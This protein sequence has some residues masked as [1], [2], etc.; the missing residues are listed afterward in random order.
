MEKPIFKVTRSAWGLGLATV[1]ITWSTFIACSSSDSNT[2]GFDNEGGPPGEGGIVIVVQKDGSFD[3]AMALPPDAGNPTPD[4]ACDFYVAT[5]CAKYDTCTNGKYTTIHYGSQTICRQREKIACL[6]NLD[7]PDNPATPKGSVRCAQ[8]IATQS[9]ADFFDRR[10]TPSACTPSSGPRDDGAPCAANGQCQSAFCH[11]RTG[12]TCGVCEEQPVAGSPCD[13]S[14]DCPRT[15]GCSDANICEPY[16]LEGGACGSTAPCGFALDC[17]I[18]KNAPAGTC[19]AQGIAPGAACD[20]KLQKA[21]LCEPSYLLYCGPGNLCTPAL[22]ASPGDMCGHVPIPSDAG[23][24]ASDDAGDDGGDD[25][26]TD[27]GTPPH[28]I[29]KCIAGGECDPPG[30]VTGSCTAPATDGA[31]CDTA[32]GPPCL[33]PAR[34][35]GDFSDGGTVGTCKILSATTCNP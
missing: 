9:C 35:V 14:S 2:N 29:A 12:A 31:M 32:N 4:S 18:P 7:Q 1:G 21:P 3:D 15:Y 19:V 20:V 27:A 26:G 10:N 30:S 17:V 16:V 13:S 5:V 24:D 33:K 22:G 25:G 23:A 11:A 34:C 6:A 8:G 28:T